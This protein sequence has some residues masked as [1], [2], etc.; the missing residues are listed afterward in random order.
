MHDLMLVEKMRGLQRPLK[1]WN[2]KMFGNIDEDI[3]KFE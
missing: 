3:N 1:I 2:K